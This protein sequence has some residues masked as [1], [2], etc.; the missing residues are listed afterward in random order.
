MLEVV[1]LHVHHGPVRAVRGVSLEVGRGQI[2]A[3][4]GANGAGKSTVLEAIS[5]IKRPITGGE[6][7]FE[8]KRID[9]TGAHALL[10]GGI[11]H[12]PEDRLIFARMSVGENLLVAAA[13][14]LSRRAALAQRQGVIERLPMLADFLDMPAASLSGGQRQLLAVGRGLMNSPRLLLLDEP[15]LGLSPIAARE[16]FDLMVTLKAE[17]LGIL[18]VDQNVRQVL[19]IADQALVLDGG[20]VRMSGPGSMLEAD[21][22]V[23]EAYLGVA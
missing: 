13:G 11:A 8:G 6:I 17:G 21:P 23:A 4:V 2:V 7:R 3:L 9:R 19:K 12:V 22:R 10:A 16:I 14:R 5:G 1:D 15:T 20:L 18:V